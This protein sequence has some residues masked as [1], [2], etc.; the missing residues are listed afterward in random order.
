MSRQTCAYAQTESTIG[1]VFTL[2]LKKMI[3][4]K[5]DKEEGDDEDTVVFD[6]GD[7]AAQGGGRGAPES[8]Q[9][10]GL[11][12]FAVQPEPS[13]N[14]QPKET[15]VAE[16]TP[17]VQQLGQ[18]PSKDEKKAASQNQGA[19]SEQLED[20]SDNLKNLVYDFRSFMS[21][22]GSPFNP[23][24]IPATRP[25]SKEAEVAQATSADV[26]GSGYISAQAAGAEEREPLENPSDVES[27]FEE[28][29]IPPSEKLRL[30]GLLEQPRRGPSALSRLGQTLNTVRPRAKFSNDLKSSLD[31]ADMP[32]LI[33]AVNSTDYLLHAVGRKNL[34]KILEV[35]TRE[36]WIRPEVERMVLSVAEILSTSGVESDDRVI[37]VADLLRVVY[38]LNRLLDPEISDLLTM[39]A[40][41]INRNVR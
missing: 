40:P 2:D 32:A 8:G 15:Q 29:R 3:G 23:N 31:S 16:P 1:G 36:G 30:T 9:R 21:E 35:G 25:D 19:V 6:M 20:L 14:A 17:Q 24:D 12:T 41:P 28:K 33:R 4:K 11:Q 5:K 26:G 27:G 34:L 38:F 39:N 37:N 18:N 10:E 22:A 7:Q 13:P